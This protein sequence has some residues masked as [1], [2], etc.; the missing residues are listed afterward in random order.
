MKTPRLDIESTPSP[1][2]RRRIE[3][4]STT[5]LSVSILWLIHS[6][7]IAAQESPQPQNSSE[8]LSQRFEE[9]QA[10]LRRLRRMLEEEEAQIVEQRKIL[11]RREMRLKELAAQLGRLPTAAHQ[12]SQESSPAGPSPPTVGEAP[13]ISSSPPAVAPI[14]QQQGVLT[15]AGTTILEPVVEFGYSTN[16]RL[17]VIGYSILPAI[18]VGYFDVS[19]VSHTVLSA[20]IA[21]RYGITNRFELEG[22]VPYVYRQD[23]TTA[24]PF[25]QSANNDQL[26]E[27]SG[28]GVGDIEFTARYQLNHGDASR[29]FYVA[30]MR[31][32]SDTGRSSFDSSLFSPL[33]GNA[34]PLQ[35]ELATGSGFWAVQPGLTALFPSDP[36]VL[37][38]SV[39]YLYNF[40]RHLD[41]PDLGLVGTVN[42]GDEIGV[43]FGMGFSLND[44]AS[45]SLGYDHTYVMRPTLNGSAL[46]L[47]MVA[48][49]GQLLLGYSYRTSPRY[50]ANLS[51]A[52]GA[53]R[54][55]PDVQVRFRLPGSF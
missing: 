23:D 30:S 35:N 34:L 33:P 12:G 49:V 39:T 42:P 28:S 46:P 14:F 37:F 5:A 4:L 8:D 2:S 9:E 16:N 29:P 43:N 7:C 3:R 32:K 31:V 15:P 54:D 53:T 41:R 48:Q 50:T 27:S 38:G 45:F 11:E 44:R 55:S 19:Q 25:G 18:N 52:V 36:A 13:A 26:Y 47:S 21:A 1:R 22:R 20:E 10:E 24:R 40:S 17:T 51:L 6:S